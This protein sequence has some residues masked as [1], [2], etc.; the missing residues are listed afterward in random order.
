MRTVQRSHIP[1]VFFTLNCA[2]NI[3]H[4]QCLMKKTGSY[5]GKWISFRLHQN[6]SITG[7]EFSLTFPIWVYL[8]VF[9]NFLGFSLLLPHFSFC[10]GFPAVLSVPAF[11]R[12]IFGADVDNSSEK[13][14]LKNNLS[15]MLLVEVQ[16]RPIKLLVLYFTILRT[17]A[18]ALGRVTGKTASCPKYITSAHILSPTCHI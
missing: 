16:V 12:A 17:M 11:Q 9:S 7:S 6:L 15:V 14:A 18:V 8:P 1:F 5:E 4:I 2:P 10:N 3:F 13:R